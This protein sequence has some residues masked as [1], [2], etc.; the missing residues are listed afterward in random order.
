VIQVGNLVKWISAANKNTPGWREENKDMVG[1][2]YERVR[3]GNI[4]LYEDWFWV[5]FGEQKMR[6][7]KKDLE[8]LN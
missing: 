4:R 3:D 5:L 2:V 7:F 1:L 8:V 6:V